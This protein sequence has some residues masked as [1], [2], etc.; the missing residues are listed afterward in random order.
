MS[1]ILRLSWPVE[2]DIQLIN[3]LIINQLIAQVSQLL[4]GTYTMLCVIQK[5]AFIISSQAITLSIALIRTLK[6][7]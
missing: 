1:T 4:Q 5:A 6:S 2:F 7:F 3:S